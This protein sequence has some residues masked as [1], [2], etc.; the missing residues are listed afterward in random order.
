M[1]ITINVLKFFPARVVMYIF[2][3]LVYFYWSPRTI[4]R[5]LYFMKRSY[6]SNL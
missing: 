2:P 4:K 5:T 1:A 3:L 6:L